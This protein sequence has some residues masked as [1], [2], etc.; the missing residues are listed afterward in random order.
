[1]GGKRQVD[2][3]DISEEMVLYLIDRE[4]IKGQSRSRQNLNSKRIEARNDSN[5]L[6]GVLSV[7][8]DRPLYIDSNLG[9]RLVDC[10]HPGVQVFVLL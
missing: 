6:P 3:I 1:M 7:M 5:E 10:I 2:S 8:L 4:K 9:F